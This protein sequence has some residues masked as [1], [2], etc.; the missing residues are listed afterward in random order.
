MSYR[1]WLEDRP[2]PLQVFDQQTVDYVEKHVPLGT[3]FNVPIAYVVMYLP[4]LLIWCRSSRSDFCASIDSYWM[5]RGSKVTPKERKDTFD[6]DPMHRAFES[7]MKFA[8]KLRD[9]DELTEDWRKKEKS[10]QA[11]AGSRHATQHNPVR[12]QS[13]FVAP[14]T[15]F[16]M[17]HA[18]GSSF[19]E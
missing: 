7:K 18:S 5:R 1:A 9:L 19:R 4:M 16:P 15:A 2:D 14:P 11:T 6:L 3:A 17:M 12:F 13:G 8:E 10:P